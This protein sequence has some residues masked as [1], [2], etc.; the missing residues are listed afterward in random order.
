VAVLSIKEN[1]APENTLEENPFSDFT[2]VL[3]KTKCRASIKI[4]IPKTANPFYAST[5]V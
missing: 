3:L 4:T 1:Y 2:V 5:H